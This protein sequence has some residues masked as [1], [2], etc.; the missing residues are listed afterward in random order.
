MVSPDHG[1]VVR[2]RR[3]AEILNTSIAIIDNPDDILDIESN[4]EKIRK[5][6]KSQVVTIS[7]FQNHDIEVAPLIFENHKVLS[8]INFYLKDDLAK[9]NIVLTDDGLKF[10]KNNL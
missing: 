1:G 3:F 10:G 8:D 5:I 4:Y 6:M 2:A 7:E 9:Q